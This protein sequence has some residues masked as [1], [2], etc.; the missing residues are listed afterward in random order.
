[1][2]ST[3][4]RGS[5]ATPGQE[6]GGTAWEEVWRPIPGL[7]RWYARNKVVGTL[8]LAAFLVAKGWVTARGD[9][10]TALGILD[11]AGIP[12]IVIGGLLSGF[13]VLAAVMLGFAIFRIFAESPSAT[14]PTRRPRLPAVERDVG[15][16]SRL[17]RTYPAVVLASVMAVVA[18]LTTPT[19]VIA[20]AAV[21]GGLI[22]GL[23]LTS[24]RLPRKPSR[25]S[26]WKHP[27]WWYVWAWSTGVIV[28]PIVVYSLVTLLYGVWLP[29]EVVTFS[30]AGDRP[31]VGYVLQD[32][33]GWMT[34][35][36]TG[37]HRIVRYRDP[38][39]IQRKLCERGAG[40]WAVLGFSTTPWQNL[41][42]LRWLSNARA[43]KTEKC[44]PGQTG[45]PTH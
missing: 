6:W 26:R 24:R 30:Q 5:R 36:R 29:H 8:L 40:G 2:T 13:P 3:G 27:W 1:M 12:T 25:R 9:V 10:S 22:G 34:I 43:T 42:E 14:D 32:S 17:V 18:C 35:L 11:T 31:E 37:E 39:V 19:L 4:Q 7:I 15:L 20:V 45:D 23:A 38:E 41:T 21:F 44:P 33:D 16:G 28:V